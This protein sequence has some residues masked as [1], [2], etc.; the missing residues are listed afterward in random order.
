HADEE[1]GMIRPPSF[2]LIL[3]LAA[4]SAVAQRNLWNLDP[5]G[6]NSA[7]FTSLQ[8]AADSPFVA[9]GDILVLAPGSYGPLDTAKPLVVDGPANAVVVHVAIHDIASGSEFV[10][11]GVSFYDPASASF[12]YV[13]AVHCAGRIVVADAALVPTGSF[14]Q[15]EL[16]NILATAGC[17]DVELA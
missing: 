3:C 2:A 17:A 8:A 13:E 14:P 10:I 5:T 16:R 1:P 9:P 11:R 15:Y 4:S 7:N 12:A 6:A